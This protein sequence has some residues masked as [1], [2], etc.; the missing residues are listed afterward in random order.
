D[1]PATGRPAR[2]LGCRPAGQSRRIPQITK[3]PSQWERGWGEGC[4]VLTAGKIVASA[5]SNPMNTACKEHW[6]AARSRPWLVPAPGAGSSAG[7]ARRAA[8]SPAR[9]C[10]Q[11]A[12]LSLGS[13]GS[14]S[15]TGG[16]VEPGA[17]ALSHAAAAGRI[18]R[19]SRR[20][21]RREL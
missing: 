14:V 12:R 18:R 3:D 2:R 13:L 8:S 11:T 19:S 16:P 15:H 10:E 6:Y 5:T 4:E 7:R 21:R 1:Y 17:A 20:G 9:A